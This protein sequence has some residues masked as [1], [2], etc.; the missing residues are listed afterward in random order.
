[1]QPTHST[2]SVD[3]TTMD[4]R[5]ASSINRGRR[6]FNIASNLTILALFLL[7][8]SFLAGHTTTTR[9]LAAPT[10]PPVELTASSSVPDGFPPDF[11]FGYLE[12]DWEPGRV[13]GFGPLYPSNLVVGNGDAILAQ[14][15]E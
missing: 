7:G 1:M 3:I 4:P 2:T 5:A 14:R 13:P 10:L 12:F 15:R 11:V 6:R 9:L 8:I